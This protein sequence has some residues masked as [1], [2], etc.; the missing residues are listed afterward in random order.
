MKG[1]GLGWSSRLAAHLWYSAGLTCVEMGS[2]VAGGFPG[3]LPPLRYCLLEGRSSSLA[4]QL[5]TK[6]K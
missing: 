4:L 6:H 1:A 2:F 5:N 3:S